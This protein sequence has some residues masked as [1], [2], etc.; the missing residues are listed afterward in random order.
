VIA[1]V[2]PLRERYPNSRNSYE[3]RELDIKRSHTLGNLKFDQDLHRV[4][5]VASRLTCNE[6]KQ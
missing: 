5:F 3:D 1:P 4:G 6:S 2:T